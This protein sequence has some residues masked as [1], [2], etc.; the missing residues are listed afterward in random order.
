MPR[1]QLVEAHNK[2]AAEAVQ[3]IVQAIGGTGGGIA[4]I[5][6]AAETIAI[7]LINNFV[8]ADERVGVAEIFGAN[9]KARVVRM[10]LQSDVMDV[11]ESKLAKGRMN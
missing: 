5:M 9:I 10:M 1:N 7:N 6:L 4:D 2:V 3:A 11:V 8:V